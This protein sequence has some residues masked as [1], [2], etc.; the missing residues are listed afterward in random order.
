MSIDDNSETF[1]RNVIAYE[2]C[3]PNVPNYVTSYV[4]AIDYLVNTPE[5]LS[6][7]IESKIVTNDLGSNE[8]ATKMINKLA[9]EV[10]FCGQ[11]LT[12]SEGSKRWSHPSRSEIWLVSP[13]HAQIPLVAR[14]SIVT[15]GRESSGVPFQ[16]QS[17]TMTNYTTWSIIMEAILDSQGLWESIEPPT[18]VAVKQKK[19]KSAKGFIFQV[20]PEDIILSNKKTAKEVWDS[21]KTRYLRA[22]RVQKARIH[23]L[24]SEFEALGM[25]YGESIDEFTGKLSGL[26]QSTTVSGEHWK[27]RFLSEKLLDSVQGKLLQLVAFIEQYSYVHYMPFKEAIGCLKAYEDKLRLRVRPKT[28]I[29][30]KQARY[31]KKI[32]QS[33]RMFHCNST[34]TP[35]EPKFNLSKDIDGVPVN[36]T[37]Y[38]RLVGCLRY[39]IHTRPDL[40]YSDGV[41]GLIYQRG[42]DG[43]LIG[44]Y[45]SSHNMDR[46]DVKGT[47]GTV[48][49]FSN[50]PISWLSQKQRTMALS[51][52]EAK[53]MTAT[54]AACQAVWL[55]NLLKDLTG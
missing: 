36:A 25:K 23:T 30:L 46:D 40:P 28:G 50:N 6:R 38:R 3:T 29:E 44:Y 13:V 27:T 55:K 53:F 51:S 17:L 34:K 42:G 43:K 4:C 16:C 7:L 18:G 9:K 21:L 52:C 54:A 48:F 10:V 15:H 35:M 14:E 11:V 47:T 41:V 45:D 31:V 2:Q 33:A 49:Y 39:L 37:D 12:E 1:L 20:L 22:E 32:L 24:K 26:Y 8:E 19:D 5:D